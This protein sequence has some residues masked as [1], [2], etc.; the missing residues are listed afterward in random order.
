[1]RRQIAPIAAAVEER[2]Q[3]TPINSTIF[4]PVSTLATPP[5]TRTAAQL[6]SVVMMIANRSNELQ[7]TVS[8][9][10]NPPGTVNGPST[11][12]L[13]RRTRIVEKDRKADRERCG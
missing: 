6:M 7:A 10:L 4:I 3:P 1:M 11:S 8:E 2:A 12:V 5:L 9:R 13:T